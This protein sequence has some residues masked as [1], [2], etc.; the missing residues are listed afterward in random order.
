MPGVKSGLDRHQWLR[1]GTC[2]T[3]DAEDYFTL[4]LRLL[5]ELNRSAVRALFAD[6]IGEELDEKQIKQAFDRSFGAGAGDR[7]RMQRAARRKSGDRCIDRFF[8]FGNHRQGVGDDDPVEPILVEGCGREV[9][10]VRDAQYGVRPALPPELGPGGRQH[11]GRDIE[12][13]EACTGVEIP[14]HGAKRMNPVSKRYCGKVKNILDW[15]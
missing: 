2:Q 13:E 15:L 12:A 1:N 5:E 10:R 4:Q 8:P 3:A 14:D 7:V 6:R 9:G 11:L